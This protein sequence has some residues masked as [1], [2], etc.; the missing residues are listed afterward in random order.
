[1]VFF[2]VYGTNIEDPSEEFEEDNDFYP[3]ENPDKVPCSPGTHQWDLVDSFEYWHVVGNTRT[4]MLREVFI[5][6]V[7]EG[8]LY[9]ET[10][11][12][13]SPEETAPEEPPIEEVPSEPT[14]PPTEPP[15]EETTPPEQEAPSEPEIPEETEP[16]QPIETPSEPPVETE[17][18]VISTEPPSQVPT[19]DVGGEFENEDVLKETEN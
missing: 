8:E 1:M 11:I 19:E 9:K 6:S 17:P 4:K 13:E 2:K 7:C 10:E 5:C 16:S 15:V 14:S 18:P 3:G 12:V